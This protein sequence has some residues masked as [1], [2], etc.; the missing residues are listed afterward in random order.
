MIIISIIGTEITMLFVKI[1]HYCEVITLLGC[2]TFLISIFMK[3]FVVTLLGSTR[4]LIT[5][6]LHSMFFLCVEIFSWPLGKT[7]ALHVVKSHQ[8]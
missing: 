2:I 4:L 6:E 8:H 5:E 3:L 1:L 7:S